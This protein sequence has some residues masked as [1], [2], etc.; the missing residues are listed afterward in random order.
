MSEIGRGEV[1]SRAG[2]KRLTLR[3]SHGRRI[4]KRAKKDSYGND[5]V[6]WL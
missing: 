6:R 2:A 5:A 1:K 3:C 4:M